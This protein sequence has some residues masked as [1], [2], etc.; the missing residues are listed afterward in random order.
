VPRDEVAAYD[1]LLRLRPSARK[2]AEQTHLPWGVPTA[3]ASA[4]NEHLLHQAEYITNYDDD[5]RVPLWVGYRLTSADLSDGFERLACFRKDPR[6]SDGAAAVCDDYDEPIFD[7][8]HLARSDDLSRTVASMINSF[9]FSNMCPQFPNF[10]RI[11]R[12][13]NALED[14]VQAWA[15]DTGVVYVITGAAFD[16]DGDG[17]RD[18]DAD[19]QRM[20]PTGRVAIPSHFYKILLHPRANGFVD[21]LCVLLPHQKNWQGTLRQWL[22]RHICT[23]SDIEEISGVDFL[24]GMPE[25]QK[26]A[27]RSFKRPNLMPPL[28]ELGPLLARA[29]NHAA[30]DAGVPLAKYPRLAE[31]LDKITDTNPDEAA[32]GYSGGGLAPMAGLA[33]PQAA[34][35]RDARYQIVSLPNSTRIVLLNTSTGDSWETDIANAESRWRYLGSRP[36]APTP[37]KAPE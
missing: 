28:S 20:Q 4:N 23:L 27:I 8:G 11:N 24:P 14:V 33:V 30:G 6:L 19:A 31:D 12:P 1:R 5:L 26:T 37:A 29:A 36:M 2:R 34:D 15:N 17:H 13:W 9:V 21:S 25:A 22:E 3:P 18:A 16:R 32:D 35:V 10:N 7:R